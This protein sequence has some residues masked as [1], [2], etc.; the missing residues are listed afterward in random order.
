MFFRGE[1]TGINKS[2]RPQIVLAADLGFGAILE[3]THELSHCAGE[4]VR[5]PDFFPTR[6]KPIAGTLGRG[7]VE[8]AGRR[9]RIVGPA[10]RAAGQAFESLD[11]PANR[12]VF[13]G[14]FQSRAS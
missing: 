8:S 3:G 11:A 7:E 2:H 1:I 10:D 14:P 5:E 6:R 13:L 9:V 4:S 12:N